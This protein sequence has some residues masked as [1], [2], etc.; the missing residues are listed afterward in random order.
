MTESGASL[1]VS[2]GHYIYKIG[3]VAAASTEMSL[4]LAVVLR[5]RLS[6]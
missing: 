6:V 3:E 2:P 5:Q 1:Q 4:L